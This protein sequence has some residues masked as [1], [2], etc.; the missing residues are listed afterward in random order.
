MMA[1]MHL[2]LRLCIMANFTIT[3]AMAIALCV[4]YSPDAL[5]TYVRFGPSPTLHI[6]GVKIDTLNKYL[7]LQAFLA[8]FQASD[9]I[10]QDIASPILGFNVFNP[11]KNII[12]GFSKNQLQFYAQSFWFI[13][14]LRSTLVLLLS[15]TQ[16]DI[17]ISK[18]V[19]SKLAGVYTIRLLLNEKR[20]QPASTND[21]E[22][23]LL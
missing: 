3:I 15:I 4:L 1:D 2:K 6:L 19:Y 5:D 14:S 16:M 22:A 21:L 20:F 7:G 13:G 12:T 8:V 11:D 17:A 18:C 9:V 23:N 10:M